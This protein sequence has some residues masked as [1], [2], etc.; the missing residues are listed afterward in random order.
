MA[1]P[2]RGWICRCQPLPEA[3][4]TLKIIAGPGQQ[5]ERPFECGRIKRRKT[6]GG[7]VL[8]YCIGGARQAHS[9]GEWR[10]QGDLGL[11]SSYLRRTLNCLHCGTRG[12]SL[13]AC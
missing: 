4:R 10:H 11:Y 13:N 3:L 9:T 8:R 7:Q 1:A 6:G 2:S 5:K 12:G